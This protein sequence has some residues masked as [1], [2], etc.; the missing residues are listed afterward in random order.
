M[1]AILIGAIAFQLLPGQASSTST[2]RSTSPAAL[3]SSPLHQPPA[4]P[5]T[6]VTSATGDGGRL[7]TADGRVPEGVTVFRDDVPA[8]AKLDPKLLAALRQAATD[9]AADGVTF[10]VNGGWR[11][12]DYQSE[13]LR[14]AEAEYG[15]EAEAARWVARPNRSQHVSGDAVDLAAAAS[16]WLSEHGA[17][18]GLCQI[19]DNERW[20]YELRPDAVTRGCPARWADAAHDPRMQE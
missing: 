9:A 14:E 2:T 16:S 17:S 6:S 1:V 15:S 4:L 12:A 3:V 5:A 11:S 20:H 7:G 10:E 18:Y 13:L 8:V 19:Y